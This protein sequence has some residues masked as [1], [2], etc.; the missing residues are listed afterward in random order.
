MIDLPTEGKETF[1]SEER[2]ASW[3][4]AEDDEEDPGWLAASEKTKMRDS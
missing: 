4:V 3:R 2:S 1:Q